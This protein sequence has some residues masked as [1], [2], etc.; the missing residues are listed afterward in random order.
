MKKMVSLFLAL[1]MALTMASFASA[2]EPVELIWWMGTDSM[3]PVDQAMVE[4][5]LNKMSA[6]ALG[7]TIKCTYM[8]NDQVKLAM[9]SGEYFDICFTS[10]GWYNDFSMNVFDG[11]FYNI[12]GKVQE[13]TPALW[14]S[15]PEM[16]WQG[17]YVNVNG[18][19]G[20]YAVPVM[21]DYGIEVFWIIDID[22]FVTEKGMEIPETM[23][24]ND[25]E[26]YLEM[27]KKDHP[28]DYPIKEARG[29]I[30][31][32]SNF[33]DWINQDVGIAL[34]YNDIGTEKEGTVYLCYEMPEY[35]DRVAKVHEWYEKGY[36]NPDAA[37]TEALPRT[38]RG[39]I[40]SGQG[41]YGADSIWSNARQKASAIS[42]FDGPFLSTYS[43]QGSLLAISAASKHVDEAL[44]MLEYVNTNAEYRNMMRYGLEGVHYTW[45]EDG[46][47]TKTQ[48]GKDNYSPWAYTQGSYSL[49]AVEAS[50]FPSVPADP[51]MWQVVWD[52]Y[53][54]A[55][56]SAALG[57]AFDY[58]PVQNQVNACI[59]IKNMYLYEMQTG[60][61]DPAEVFPQIIKEM[62]DAGIRDVIAEA[63][64]QLDEF[65]ASKK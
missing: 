18:E 4:A 11:M 38:A 2:S 52:G 23:S 10:N 54:D 39:V 64:K 45:N 58:T 55:V 46:T 30:T 13:L 60:T 1:L 31:S 40:Q 59:A 33:L 17:S 3:A 34:S 9:S 49:S 25:I 37:V 50:P 8:T 6:E 42:R 21:K 12:D 43:L 5:E 22:Y 27:Y 56:T 16:L 35:I 65:L 51:N 32:W 48:Q 61:S 57:F 36:I 20:L 7:I 63:Q 14:E 47:V 62:E 29:G 26:P 24:F 41:F 53:K 19:K 28:E 15:M 44:K